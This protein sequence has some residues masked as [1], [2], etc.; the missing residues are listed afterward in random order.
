MAPNGIGRCQKLD[1]R[2]YAGFSIMFS[3]RLIRNRSGR[4]ARDLKRACRRL[5]TIDIA[6]D[7]APC[8]GEPTNR[9]NSL[10]I[11]ALASSAVELSLSS[12]LAFL[13]EYVSEDNANLYRLPPPAGGVRSTACAD[14]RVKSKQQ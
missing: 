6:M 12:E 4:F 10:R 1:S 9:S 14:V 11:R 7:S 3:S 13:T 5:Q 2:L 8:A